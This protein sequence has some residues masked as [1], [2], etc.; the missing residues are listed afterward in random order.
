MMPVSGMGALYLRD[1]SILRGAVL[2]PNTNGAVAFDT[3]SGDRFEGEFNVTDGINGLG[4]RWRADGALL[5][6]GI[7]TRGV[8][9]TPLTP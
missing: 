3:A 8:L 2:G 5:E 7:W 1:G 6:Q 4:A 9:T